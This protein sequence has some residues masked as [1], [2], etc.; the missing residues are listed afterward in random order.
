MNNLLIT[1]GCGFVGTNFLNYLLNTKD[2]NDKELINQ[3]DSIIIID[4]L[5]TGHVMNVH[6][7]LSKKIILIKDDIRNVEV[8]ASI[9]KTYKPS[10]CL[11]LAGLVS[12]YDCNKNPGKCFDHNV[13]GTINI[14]NH[15]IKYDTRIVAAETSAVYEGSGLPPY[16]ENQSNPVTMYAISKATIANI[17]QS[18]NKFYELD[19][20]LLRFFNI[21]GTLQD[22]RRTIPA[23]HCGFVARVLQNKPV[24]IFGDGNRRRDFIHV[25]DICSFLYEKCIITKKYSNNTYNLGTGKSTSL[26]EI[27]DMIYNA[28]PNNE[29]K[30]PLVLPEIN[31]EAFDIYAN[32]DKA[33]ATGWRP[34]KTMKNIIDDTILYIRKE[35]ELDNIHKNFM[36]D[37]EMNLKKIKL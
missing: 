6:T 1:G 30:E 32:I 34:T 21:A 31:G 28:L 29:S 10:V 22:Y 11:H 18:Y 14:L 19:Y 3:F 5:S 20:I 37:T 33:L 25:D 4:N 23:L 16:T 15:C 9:F 13:I 12:I 24:I 17:I 2:K 26:Y 27:R 8:V 7:K 35:I 36:D